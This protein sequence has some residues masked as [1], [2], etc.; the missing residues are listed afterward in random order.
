MATSDKDRKKAQRRRDKERLAEMG[1]KVVEFE[2]P[3]SVRK[4]MD[5][6]R[7]VR[8]GITPYD[9]NE[10][11]VTLILNDYERLQEQEKAWAK[12][13]CEVCGNGLP[14]GCKDVFKGQ[15]NCWLRMH[16]KEVALHV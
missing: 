11:I 16:S 7:N 5:Y 6:C 4:K 12:D 8:G 14:G 10:F 2:I 9:A 1:M 13:R 15:S 3:E